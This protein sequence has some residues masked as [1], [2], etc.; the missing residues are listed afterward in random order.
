MVFT[1]DPLELRLALIEV[2]ALCFEINTG[3]RLTFTHAFAARHTLCWLFTRGDFHELLEKLL[4]IALNIGLLHRLLVL[5]YPL[6]V[7]EKPLLVIL[8][9]LDLLLGISADL[10]A[11]CDTR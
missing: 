1:L 5:M 2:Q 3:G 7:P 6:L 8:A 11:P 9:E 4:V 10:L